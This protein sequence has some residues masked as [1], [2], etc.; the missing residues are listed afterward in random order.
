[1]GVPI[2]DN[3]VFG[4]LVPSRGVGDVKQVCLDVTVYIQKGQSKI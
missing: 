4:V 2:R 3:R 1:M